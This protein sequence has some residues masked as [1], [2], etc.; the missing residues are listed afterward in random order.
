MSNLLFSYPKQA[1]FGRVVP[2]SKIYEYAKPTRAVRDLFV[3]QINQITWQYKLAPETINLPARV[4]VPEIQVFEI[5]LKNGELSEA[6]LRCIDNAIPYPIIYQLVFENK[7]KIVAAYKRRYQNDTGDA[8]VS[9]WVV[10]AYFESAW[11]P[12]DNPT[13]TLP[14]ALDLAGLYE[15]ILRQLMPLPPLVGESL[16]SHV[17]R[18]CMVRTKQNEASKLQSSLHKEKQFNRKVALNAQLRNL[19]NELESLKQ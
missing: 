13:T 5:S 7:I 8:D 16:K 4:G 2:K 9:K 10:D 11:L 17:A 6:V 14:I 19:Q 15:Q 12:A 18:M 1:F 3:S